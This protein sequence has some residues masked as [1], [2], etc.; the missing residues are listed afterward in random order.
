MR[1]SEPTHQSMN[2]EKCAAAFGIMLKQELK[3]DDDSK[4]SHPALARRCCGPPRSRV[5]SL[6]LRSA[7]SSS[8]VAR[9]AELAISLPNGPT[10]VV[11]S[12]LATFATVLASFHPGRLGLSR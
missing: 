6:R 7:P 1:T 5:E 3:R 2:P 8:T 12:I 4:K 11:T 10:P 9:D